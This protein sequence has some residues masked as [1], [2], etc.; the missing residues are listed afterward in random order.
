[1][2]NFFQ[3]PEQIQMAVFVLI[4][5]DA[6][7]LVMLKKMKIFSKLNI[8]P[9]R[10]LG[11]GAMNTF[12]YMLFFTILNTEY[13]YLAA[14]IAAF[15]LSGAISYFLTT[16]YTFETRV[17]WKTAMQFPLTFMPN[18]IFS[19]IGT[20]VLVKFDILNENIASITMMLIAIPLTFII[21]KLIFKKK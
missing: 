1:M 2:S 16:M 11:V 21:S 5:L 4:I 13:E 9:I 3:E 6:I 18:L 17:S 12:S 20:W 10:F 14:H 15:L 7:G 19:T 8:A